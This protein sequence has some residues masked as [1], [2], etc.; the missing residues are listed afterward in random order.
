MLAYRSTSFARCTIHRNRGI[1]RSPSA[2]PDGD[3]GQ[4]DL[5]SPAAIDCSTVF[6][7]TDTRSFEHDRFPV[8]FRTCSA[9]NGKRRRQNAAVGLNAAI[10]YGQGCCAFRRAT[11]TSR[12]ADRRA[13]LACACRGRR[14]ADGAVASPAAHISGFVVIGDTRSG[15]A[16]TQRVAHRRGLPIA[17]CVFGPRGRG[18]RAVFSAPRHVGCRSGASRSSVAIPRVALASTLA[19]GAYRGPVACRDDLPA[20]SPPRPPI[21]PP[22][23]RPAAPPKIAPPIACL[24]CGLVAQRPGAASVRRDCVE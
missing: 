17:C 8:V 13:I 10:F 11:G 18:R 21:S 19:F 3:A 12:C 15:A 5:R 9:P 23:I 4:P 14:R 22:R 1:P 16:H 24:L 20:T 2:G 6:A 7:T